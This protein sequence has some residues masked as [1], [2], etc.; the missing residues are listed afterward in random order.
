MSSKLSCFSARYFVWP[1]YF[2][3]KKGFTMTNVDYESLALGLYEIGAVKFGRFELQS[4]R[5]SP[6]YVDLRVMISR[7]SL[8]RQAAQAYQQLLA[9]LSFDLLGAIPYGGLPIG[10]AI[11]LEMN[12][13]MI[14]HR[15]QAKNYGT[16]R[17][18]E[19]IWSVGQRVV[20]IEDVI[21][22]G[23]SILQGIAVLKAAGLQVLDAAVLINRQQGGAE[24][25][26]ANGYTLHS[27]F[28]LEKLLD[29][30]LQVKKIDTS[31]Y[32]RVIASQHQNNPLP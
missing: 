6:I 12:R 2:G 31:L 11:A 22:S 32:Q 9:P 3:Y 13:P 5:I 25:L 16:G 18:I 21:T 8:L 23:E 26:A 28:T 19:G 4:G 7:P 29:L 17:Q 20:I 14:F 1:L 24:N 15:K 27:V 10:T 30:L